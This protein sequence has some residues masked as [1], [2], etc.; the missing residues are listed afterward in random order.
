VFT[1]FHLFGADEVATTLGIPDGVTQVALLPVAYTNGTDFKPA[2]RPP[3]EQ[4]TYWNIWG[5]TS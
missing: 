5:E 2:T 3:V 1:T 4:I